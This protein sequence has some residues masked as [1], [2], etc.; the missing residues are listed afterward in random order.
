MSFGYFFFFLEIWTDTT[1]VKKKNWRKKVGESFFSFKKSIAQGATLTLPIS[2]AS[3][4]GELQL[5]GY[6]NRPLRLPS[7]E[8]AS[9]QVH[10]KSEGQVP[11]P[12]FLFCMCCSLLRVSPLL[13]DLGI[14][15]IVC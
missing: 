9:A 2:A 14:V 1:L 12:V 6:Y 10:G 13:S 11:N 8:I 3:L 5:W 7:S 4:F 15:T